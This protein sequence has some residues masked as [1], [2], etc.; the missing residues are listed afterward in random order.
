MGVYGDLSH[1]I[2]LVSM[3]LCCG[4]AVYSDQS[5]GW[6]CVEH[7]QGGCCPCEI[8]WLEED[9]TDSYPAITCQ[10]VRTS[11]DGS[12]M[13]P[14]PT[15]DTLS[16]LMF[17]V[18]TNTTCH[19]NATLRRRQLAVDEHFAVNRVSSVASGLSIRMIAAYRGLIQKG[20][21][22][23]LRRPDT[24]RIYNYSRYR[25]A[26]TRDLSIPAVRRVRSLPAPYRP[27]AGRLS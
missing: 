9:D 8:D 17:A 4:I 12:K 2:A 22:F 20:N 14:R 15:S 3:Q 26:A 18:T 27:P 10:L 19:R 5:L 23:R 24:Y 16:S 7:L 25:F 6:D 11:P 1:L 13:V 21:N